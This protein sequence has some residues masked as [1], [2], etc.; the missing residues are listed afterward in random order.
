MFPSSNC[1]SPCFRGKDFLS[2]DY[3]EICARQILTF[4]LN[5][6]Y[7]EQDADFRFRTHPRIVSN[8]PV[9]AGV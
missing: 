5:A 4:L 6:A 1:R 2:P 9:P 3:T 8:V 7:R